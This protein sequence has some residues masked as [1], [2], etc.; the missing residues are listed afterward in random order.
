MDIH[1]FYAIVE[2]GQVASLPSSLPRTHEPTIMHLPPAYLLGGWPPV[3][4]TSI[5]T[6]ACAILVY[7]LYIIMVYVWG[8][9]ALT[10]N[11]PSVF[12]SM[13]TKSD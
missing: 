6:T 7:T 2:N 11:I 4:A 13:G 10:A 3:L 1:Q 5:A 12:L 9:G 8:K